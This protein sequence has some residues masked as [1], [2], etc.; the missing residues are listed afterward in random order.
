MTRFIIRVN[1][2]V[3]GKKPLR[4]SIRDYIILDGDEDSID[5]LS[6]RKNI[7]MDFVSGT[8]SLDSISEEAERMTLKKK[9]I[10]LL[11]DKNITIVF[12]KIVVIEKRKNIFPCFNESN[13]CSV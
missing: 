3:N 7:K 10:V 4:G 5:S 9:A 1:E 11:D 13:C 12:G 8:T 6:G 2:R